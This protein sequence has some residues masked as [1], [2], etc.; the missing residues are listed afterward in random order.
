MIGVFIDLDRHSIPTMILD[1]LQISIVVA[2]FFIA[3]STTGLAEISNSQPVCISL[4]GA[5]SCSQLRSNHQMVQSIESHFQLTCPSN[6]LPI[7]NFQKGQLVTNTRVY[8]DDNAE[9]MK[10]EDLNT[11]DSD[12][13]DLDEGDSDEDDLV[14]DDLDEDDLDEDD[15]DE[16]D[17]DG[18]DLDEE[19]L[20]E[21]D[22]DGEDDAED[23]E[24][25]DGDDL[26]Y[27][28]KVNEFGEYAYDE[29]LSDLDD[30]DDSKS[31]PNIP[32][33]LNILLN[34][35]SI[36]SELPS[37]P[38]PVPTESNGRSTA[39]VDAHEI[40]ADLKDLKIETNLPSIGALTLQ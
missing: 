18:D 33:P 32:I 17:L 39:S 31:H 9:K 26:D 23:G 38:T 20:D 11:E 13:D 22:L 14:V 3:G 2:F 19:D 12:D 7:L 1:K 28:V 36:A 21:D 30:A 4:H 24:S 29:E 6:S 34:S 10:N 27:F 15:L 5:P 35:F 40:E 16:E 25:D 37:N 8:H